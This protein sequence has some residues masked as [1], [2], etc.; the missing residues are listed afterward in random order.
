M[1]PS[2]SALAIPL[3]TAA[4]WQH[5]QDINYWSTPVFFGSLML[6]LELECHMVDLNCSQMVRHHAQAQD[7]WVH[8]AVSMVVLGMNGT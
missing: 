2:L 1:V 6:Q 7:H 8:G 5:S 4:R 3:S